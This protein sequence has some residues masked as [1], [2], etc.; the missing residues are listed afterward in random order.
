[1]R[2]RDQVMVTF[3]KQQILDSLENLNK[4]PYLP[5]RGEI[6][7]AL[8]QLRNIAEENQQDVTILDI[9]PTGRLLYCVVKQKYI[10]LV[11]EVHLSISMTIDECLDSLLANRFSPFPSKKEKVPTSM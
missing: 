5:Y 2:E 8:K 10:A 11:P 6:W 3:Y 7:D 1:M 4:M 9:Q